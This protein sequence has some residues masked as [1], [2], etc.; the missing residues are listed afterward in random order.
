[1]KTDSV[2]IRL[3]QHSEG[4]ISYDIWLDPPS[5]AT[6]ALE[7]TDSDDGGLCIDEASVERGDEFSPK[8]YEDALGMAAAQAIE[9]LKREDREC[10][11][12]E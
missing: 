6:E 10:E 2:F 1:M 4:G 3:R 9:L 12:T 7:E 11:R 8:D 5:E